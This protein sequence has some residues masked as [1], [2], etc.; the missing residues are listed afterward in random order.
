MVGVTAEPLKDAEFEDFRCKAMIYD[1]S[2][3]EVA[4]VGVAKKNGC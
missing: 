2:N 4:S 1:F 3:E